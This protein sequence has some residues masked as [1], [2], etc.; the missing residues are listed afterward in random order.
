M[1]YKSIH[2]GENNMEW[3]NEHSGLLVL[4][5]S[6]VIIAILALVICL[7]LSLRNKLAVQKLKFTGLYSL[8]GESRQCY[9]NL[10]IG[11]KSLSDVSLR[12]LGIQNG[13]VNIPLTAYYKKVKNL[14]DDAYIVVEQRGAI[15]FDLPIEELRKLVLEM[16]GKKVL[17]GLKLYA[18]DMIGTVYK[19][20]IP[21]VKK[22]VSEMLAAEKKGIEFVPPVPAIKAEAAATT[23]EIKEIPDAPKE[24]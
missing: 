21:T 3:L 10:I 16:N 15:T 1:L 20:K 9:G 11:N 13:K 18:V 14:M 22:L 7:L 5:C 6:I 8:D 4:I 19:G 23:E 12:E 17:H 2:K 24:S